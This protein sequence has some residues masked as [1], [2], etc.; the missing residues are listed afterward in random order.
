[1]KVIE[2]FPVSMT[3]EYRKALEEKFLNKNWYPVRRVALYVLL[4]PGEELIKRITKSRQTTKSFMALNDKLE[5]YLK[6]LDDFRKLVYAGHLRIASAACYSPEY[7]A[8]EQELEA[9][10]KPK[11]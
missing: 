2:N 8:I 11:H 6:F 5:E 9:E 3:E 10:R 7:R 4:F 1:M